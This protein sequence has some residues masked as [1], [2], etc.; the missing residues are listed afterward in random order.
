MST[1]GGEIRLLL[2]KNGLFPNEVKMKWQRNGRE[3]AEKW[4]SIAN[5]T[6]LEICYTVIVQ[7]CRETRHRFRKTAPRLS[8]ISPHRQI[9][10]SFYLDFR[11]A[12]RAQAEDNSC[13]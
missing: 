9:R 13:A 8:C 6:Q 4:H 7:K 1:N 5:D 3:M 12:T 2:S 10:C 11:F